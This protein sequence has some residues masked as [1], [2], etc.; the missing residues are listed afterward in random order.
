MKLLNF[1]FFFLLMPFLFCGEIVLQKGT[2]VYENFQQFRGTYQTVPAGFYVSWDGINISSNSVDFMGVHAGGARTGG[3]YAWLINQT[4]YTMGCQPTA[5]KFTPGYFELRIVNK[6]GHPMEGV[7]VE[8]IIWHL[9]DADRSGKIKLMKSQ[10]ENLFEEIEGSEFITPVEAA[11]PAVWQNE[12]R[13]LKIKFRS[14][15]QN[16]DKLYLRWIIDDAEGSGSRDEI[17]LDNVLLK[18]IPHAGFV[19]SIQ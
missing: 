2:V 1:I 3:C 5:D 16:N 12:K 9:N 7:V 11:Q 13:T 18:F 14:P 10:K 8:Y 6:T 19:I 4:N 17:G 15:L